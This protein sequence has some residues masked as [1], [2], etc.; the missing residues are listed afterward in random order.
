VWVTCHQLRHTLG[1]HLAERR[2]QPTSIQR[3][4]GHA[5]LKTTESYIHISD[6][7]VM[8]DYAVA[9]QDVAQRLPLPVLPL[10]SLPGACPPDTH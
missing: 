7:V 8:T 4:F 10:P 3:L 6:R 5:R 2:V 9:M 1:R